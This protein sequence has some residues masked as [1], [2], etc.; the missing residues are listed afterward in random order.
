MKKIILLVGISVLTLMS[1][2]SDITSLNVNPK[3]PIENPSSA[4]LFS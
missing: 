4:Y 2:E 3:A 1:C